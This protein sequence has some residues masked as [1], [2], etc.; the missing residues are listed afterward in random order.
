M[1]YFSTVMLFWI[2]PSH[3]IHIMC[4]LQLA[5]LGA[6]VGHTGFD[7][8]VLKGRATLPGN[9]FHYLHH[10]HF[11]CNYSGVVIPLDRWFGTFHDG[12]PAAHAEMRERWVRR[13]GTPGK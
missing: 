4:A 6:G 12:S 10:R 1:V 3:P 8:L 7:K 13:R 5:A 11:V 2:V 9:F